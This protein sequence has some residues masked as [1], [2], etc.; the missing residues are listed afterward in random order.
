M[1]DGQDIVTRVRYCDQSGICMDVTPC[2][3]SDVLKTGNSVSMPIPILTVLIM[4]KYY[5]QGL[6][7][8]TT[9]MIICALDPE[10][11]SNQSVPLWHDT[12]NA[13]ENWMTWLQQLAQCH[14]EL[15][16]GVVGR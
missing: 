10:I 13:W 9:K 5:F 1:G 2:L 4:F 11:P 8:R 3:T 14:V 7:N 15:Q 16:V 6:Q 12:S